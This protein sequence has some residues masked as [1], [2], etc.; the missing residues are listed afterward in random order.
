MIFYHRT[1]KERLTSI[2]KEGLKINQESHLTLGSEW[3]FYFY[4]A[5]PIFLGMTKYSLENYKESS[6]ILLE[7]NLPEDFEI[8]SDLPSLV[9]FGAYYDMD[10]GCM[11]WKNVDDTPDLLKDFLDENGSI[12]IRDLIVFYRNESIHT[13][14]TACVLQNIPSRYIKKID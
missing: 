12:S 7:I 6:P 14:K 2:L 3:S 8:T 5:R 10:S 13:T 9:D 1:T 11:W 4:E